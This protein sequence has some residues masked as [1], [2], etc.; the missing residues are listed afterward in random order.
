MQA[1]KVSFSPRGPRHEVAEDT[2]FRIGVTST[3]EPEA[4]DCLLIDLSRNGCKAWSS[5]PLELGR[6]VEVRLPLEQIGFDSAL[7][8]TVR[9]AEPAPNSDKGFMIGFLF[10]EPAPLEVIGE[11]ILLGV[12]DS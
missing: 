10:D 11:L 2:G 7:T 3:G 6:K 8:A 1:N 4:I 5:K 9:W 12:I